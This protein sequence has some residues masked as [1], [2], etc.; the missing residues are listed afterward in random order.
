MAGNRQGAD[1]VCNAERYVLWLLD[2][3]IAVVLG[4]S[5]WTLILVWRCLHE[6]RDT[7]DEAIKYRDEVRL[8]RNT[9][10]SA[11]MASDAVNKQRKGHYD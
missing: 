2:A 8:L 6:L 5:L 11:N 3:G 9:W 7:R 1:L 10:K 4:C